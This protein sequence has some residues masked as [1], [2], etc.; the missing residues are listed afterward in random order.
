MAKIVS[1]NPS[2]NFEVIGEVEVSTVQEIEHAVEKANDAKT[3]WKELGLDKRIKFL[4]PVQEE[5]KARQNE[6]A[7]LISSEVGKPI[8]ESLQEVEEYVE[9]F[10]WFMD[11]VKTS[12]AEEVTFE[13]KDS[14]HKVV[15][16]PYGVAAV[17]MPWNFPFG[18]SI[19]G[20]VPNL[21]VGNTVVF[22]ISEECPIVGKTV[23]EIFNNH[24]LPGGVFIE[25]Y[26]AGNEG[27][28]LAKSSVN[29]IRFTGSTKV[30]RGL[31]K[32]AAEKFIKVLLE[33]GGSSPCIVFED[34]DIQKA[35]EV[36]YSSRFFNTGQTCD[37]TKRLIVHESIANDMVQALKSLI[38]SKKLGDSLDKDTDLGSLVAERQVLAIEEQVRDAISRGAKAI[39]GGKR[40]EK[41]KG[42]YFDPTLLTDV[43]TDMRVWTE[44]VFGPVLPVITFKTEEEAIRLANDTE[45][46]L[47]GRVITKDFERASRV[48]SKIEAGTVEINEAD[49]WISPANPFGGY[50]LSGLGRENGTV[51]FRELCQIKLIST[52]K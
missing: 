3:A 45:Y 25:L 32:I 47:G 52:S 30:G 15:Y 43:T 5:F 24:E 7:K 12:L 51:G 22:K 34:M 38:E 31:Y 14:V 50:K 19:C 28:K 13:D 39:T 1:T 20:I 36:V 37:T 11:N 35:A 48:A 6:I 23:E 4:R 21:L 2:R 29:L 16:E 44:E 33:M 40:L 10:Q 46:G 26:G 42:A 8:N 17:I 27:E 9:E 49:R 18:M 41:L